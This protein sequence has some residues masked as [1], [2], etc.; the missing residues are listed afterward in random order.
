MPGAG[1]QPAARASGPL[2][3]IRS[4]LWPSRSERHGPLPALLVALT[5]LTGVVDAASYLRLGHVFVAN[6]TGN[7]V[8]VGFA[9]A[10]AGGLS[11]A[12]SL[13]AIGAFVLGAFAGGWLASRSPDQRG[14]ILRAA[15]GAQALFV[16][17]ALVLA[18][19]SAAPIT[20]ST[21]YELIVPL[22]VAMGVQNAAA[23]RLAVPELTTT[24]LTKT[25]VGIASEWRALG[26]HGAQA[27]RRG[28]AV[29]AMLLGALCGGL[30]VL[31][32]SVASALGLALALALGV[33]LL[34][35]LLSQD[36]A[37][38]RRTSV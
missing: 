27:G 28:I 31:K 2:S 23:Q 4:T 16:L 19:T 30:L 24:V 15:A 29:V 14:H 32:I 20:S 35:H 5:F 22:G 37:G 26:G 25:L 9:L 17:L 18:L 8:F 13:A 36:D 3:E 34:V 33:A 12:A 6:M 1:T 10:G 11:L 38:W 7:V 21:R